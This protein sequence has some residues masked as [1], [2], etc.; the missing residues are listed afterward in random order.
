M[1]APVT[2]ARSRCG[3]EVAIV[4]TAYQNLTR[5]ACVG[6]RGCTGLPTVPLNPGAISSGGSGDSESALVQIPT[7]RGHGG[8]CDDNMQT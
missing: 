4:L 6:P 5:A 8:M 1:L 7:L 2:I 3:I